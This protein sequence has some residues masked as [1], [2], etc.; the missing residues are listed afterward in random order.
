MVRP[1]GFGLAIGVLF[2][3]FVVR[4][5]LVPS[6]MHLLGR[7]A[8][9]I[10]RWLDRVLPNVDIEGG[11]LERTHPLHLEHDERKLITAAP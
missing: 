7:G 1:L 9:W 8:W 2:D 3:A 5:V 4:M 6:A 11:A 10:P